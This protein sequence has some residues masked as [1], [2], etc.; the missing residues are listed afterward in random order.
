V[1]N[2]YYIYDEAHQALTGERSG[3]GYRLG[4][5]IRVK[6]AEAAP[7]AGALRFEILSEGRKMPTAM[8]SFHKSGK[9][10]NA[11]HARKLPGTRPP[12]GRR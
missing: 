4:D 1:G 9:R 5:P 8:R 2:D 11:R 6:L 12:R 3:L 7:L 10:G